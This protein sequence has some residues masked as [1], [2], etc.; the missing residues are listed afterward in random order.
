MTPSAVENDR[1]PFVGGAA[2]D[3]HAGRAP[4]HLPDLLDIAVLLRANL[5]HRRLLIR[6]EA[7]ADL[8]AK[9]VQGERV[10]SPPPAPCADV[11]V[12]SLAR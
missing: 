3:A 5:L 9:P 1:H 7:V 11:L 10:A 4:Q 2:A 8:D 12:L 6:P